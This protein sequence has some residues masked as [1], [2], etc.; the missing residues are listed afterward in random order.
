MHYSAAIRD[1]EARKARYSSRNAGSDR[2]FYAAWDEAKHP[3]GQPENSGEFS[4]TP[5]TKSTAEK[6]AATKKTP[7]KRQ[8]PTAKTK[9]EIAKASHYMVDAKIQRYAEEHNEKRFAKRIGGLSLDDNEPVDVV[10]PGLGPREH[11]IELKTMV[12]N[13]NNKITMKRSAMEAKAKWERKHKAKI[14]TVV[15]DDSA[16]F[17]ANGDGEHDESK[18]RIFY[19]RG[20]GSFRVGTMYEVKG[21]MAELKQLLNVDRKKLPQGAA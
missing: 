9:S 19:R 14:H 17:N 7:V 5:G 8:E 13:K 12:E 11:G 4:K 2:A 21:G 15:L 6:S 10:L 1:L 3:R 16:V 20:Y 18:R